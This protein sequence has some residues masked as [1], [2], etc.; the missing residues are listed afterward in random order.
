LDGSAT[1]DLLNVRASF[2]ADVA[3]ATG[4]KVDSVIVQATASYKGTPLA[5]GPV[6]FVFHVVGVLGSP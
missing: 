2:L 6:T 3:I 5:G 4:Q 1:N